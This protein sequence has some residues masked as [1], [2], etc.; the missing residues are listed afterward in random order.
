MRPEL[1]KARSVYPY[2]GWAA[3]AV[4]YLK[5][6]DEPDRA[7]HLAPLMAPL[8][9]EMGLFTALVPVPLHRSRLDRRGFNQAALLAES[10]SESTNIPV[11]HMLNRVTATTPQASL[12][13]DERRVNVSAAFALAPEWV[14]TAADRYLLIDDVRTSGATLNACGEILVSAGAQEVCA[15]TFALDLQSRDLREFMAR[16]RTP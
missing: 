13:L 3:N 14:P 7:R 9:A 6:R 4:K 1:A 12:T 10:V 8:V 5:Y 11:Q 16:H 15:L 2:A